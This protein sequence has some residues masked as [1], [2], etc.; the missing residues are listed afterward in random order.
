MH[1][2]SDNWHES[3][4]QIPH[5][6][7]TSSPSI[8][9]TLTA[10]VDVILAWKYTTSG[11]VMEDDLACCYEFAL[12]EGCLPLIGHCMRRDSMHCVAG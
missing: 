12:L 1:T 11:F 6:H 3:L 10:S 8:L 7:P 2:R 9:S 5:F 4:T